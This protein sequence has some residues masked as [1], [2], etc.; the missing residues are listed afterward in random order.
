MIHAACHINSVEFCLRMKGFKYDC[1]SKKIN[2]SLS[3][4]VQALES[5]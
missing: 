2:K 4:S 5:T 1:M 3:R